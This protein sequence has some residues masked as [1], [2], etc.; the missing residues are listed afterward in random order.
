MYEKGMS[1]LSC[2]PQS[3]VNL[4]VMLQGQVLEDLFSHEPVLVKYR[5]FTGLSFMCK[6]GFLYNTRVTSDFCP[7]TYS[8]LN[9]AYGDVLLYNRLWIY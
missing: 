4:P 5:H 3:S 1:L 7:E 6:R 8:I 9:K 2:T